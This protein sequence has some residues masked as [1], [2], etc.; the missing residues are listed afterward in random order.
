MGSGA[1]LTSPS[2]TNGDVWNYRRLQ[3]ISLRSELVL[4]PAV[5]TGLRFLSDQVSDRTAQAE[6]YRSLAALSTAE[7]PI[8]RAERARIEIPPLPSQVVLI[9]PPVILQKRSKAE[10]C[11]SNL[12]SDISVMIAEQL[13]R[14]CSAAYDCDAPTD[15]TQRLR[16]FNRNEMDSTEEYF[17]ERAK[18]FGDEMVYADF[19]NMLRETTVL[20]KGEMLSVENWINQ[21]TAQVSLIAVFSIPYNSITTVLRM[22]WDKSAD[23]GSGRFRGSINL[24]SYKNIPPSELSTFI[25]YIIVNIFLNIM[26][27][28]FIAIQIKKRSNQRSE[29]LA[30]VARNAGRAA[31]ENI[32]DIQKSVRVLPPI[33]VYD[34][35][36]RIGMILLCVR[37]IL[38]KS[39]WFTDTFTDTE[40]PLS[41]MDQLGQQLMTIDWTGPRGRE[42]NDQ[43]TTLFELISSISQG[44]FRE[45]TLRRY[46]FFMLALMLVRL[47]IYLNCHPRIAILYATIVQ[48]LDDLFH[49]SIVFAVIFRVFAF[50][51]SWTIGSENDDFETTTKALLTQFQ[52][53]AGGSVPLSE[54]PQGVELC[55]FVA[56]VII[57]FVIMV[58]CF[59]LAVIV[60]AYDGVATAIKESVIEHNFIFDV[61]VSFQYLYL[62]FASGHRWPS[63]KLLLDALAATDVHQEQEGADGAI[64]TVK[65]LA[66]LRDIHSGTQIFPDEVTAKD[67]MNYYLWITPYLA[68][69]YEPLHPSILKHQQDEAHFSK[70]ARIVA[71]G[72]AVT[73]EGLGNSSAAPPAQE[74]NGRSPLGGEAT[75]KSDF[76]LDGLHLSVQDMHVKMAVDRVNSMYGGE[77]RNPSPRSLHSLNRRLEGVEGQLQ[78]ILEG[79]KPAGAQGQENGTLAGVQSQLQQILA[80]QEEL[81]Q[82]LASMQLRGTDAQAEPPP[83]SVAGPEQTA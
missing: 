79:S 16:C 66:N 74:E 40:N 18:S 80:G 34:L 15:L 77:T 20:K 58:N 72:K 35:L 11:E 3:K 45:I 65:T 1:L 69:G 48:S 29:L 13:K 73:K 19:A 78:Q 75:S 63:R 22:T 60:S 14:K 36:M 51:A 39:Y 2:L 64:I 83:P 50:A 55:Y 25:F 47:I 81:R 30:F 52:M 6:F 7:P 62:Q 42:K 4:G 8:P 54:Q 10:A 23:D 82:T 68:H 56:F 17:G 31:K 37:I 44:Q 33:D 28:V 53:V 61:I 9:A 12:A 38:Q 27:I 57:I 76:S 26:D 49:F 21:Q 32:K 59:L 70:I 5:I 41:E 71:S 67:W 46:A 24:L 43:F